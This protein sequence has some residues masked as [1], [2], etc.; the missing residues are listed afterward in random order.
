MGPASNPPAGLPARGG[1]VLRCPACGSV[2]VIVVVSPVRRA[3]CS[4]CG[5]RWVQDGAVQRDIERPE[6]ST[7]GQSPPA[8]PQPV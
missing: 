8:T 6:P 3:F 4:R 7:P 1:V 5:V 2:R